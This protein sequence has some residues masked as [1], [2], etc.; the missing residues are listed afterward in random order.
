VD[1]CKNVPYANLYIDILKFMVLNKVMSF[2]T[3]VMGDI[4]TKTN[5]EINKTKLEQSAVGRKL[6]RD[7][8][9]YKKVYDQYQIT[10]KKRNQLMGMYEDVN[11][12]SQSANISYY[13]WFI[14]AISGMFLVI[15]KLKS[16]N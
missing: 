3:K 8:Q 9:K 11:F 14:L 1:E 15:K 2:K 12:K 13:I 16:S 7:M 10:E 4:V 5:T 6:L